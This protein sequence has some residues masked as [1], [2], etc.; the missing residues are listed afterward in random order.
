MQIKIFNRILLYLWEVFKVLP[1]FL[2]MK[3]LNIYINEKLVLNKDT[4]KKREYKY[5]PKTKDELQ[6]IIKQLLDEHK[7]DDMIDLNDIDTSKITDM[8]NL[9]YAIL[10]MKYPNI[11]KID[12]S[13]WDVSKV[14]NMYSIFEYCKN[15]E[16]VGDLSSWDVSNVTDMNYIFKECFSLI[17]LGDLSDWNIKKVSNF[18]YAFYNCYNLKY[19]GDISS[20]DMSKVR[21]VKK[22]FYNCERLTDDI[23]DLDNWN[24]KNAKNIRGMLF[25]CK[26]F[27]TPTFYYKL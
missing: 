24:L 20:W 16:S 12:V 27:K 5:F 2:Y 7:D 9:F 17:S 25:G 10:P 22:M 14:T 3:A 15:L 1:L 19:I 18:D 21:S 23:G 26:S 4:F 11:K 8:S 13:S 6:K